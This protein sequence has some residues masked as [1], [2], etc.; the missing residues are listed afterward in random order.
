MYTKKAVIDRLEQNQAVIQTNDGQILLWDINNLPPNL[1]E[2][3]EVV[4]EVKNLAEADKE[5]QELAKSIL[6]EIF[7]PA[8][9]GAQIT[10]ETT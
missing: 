5:Q 6:D 1:S 10:K 8:M 2:G 7:N 3:D 9:S 4:I